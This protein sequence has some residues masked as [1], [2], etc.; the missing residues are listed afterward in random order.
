[1]PRAIDG[2]PRDFQPFRGFF[3]QA[4]RRLIYVYKVDCIAPRWRCT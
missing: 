1:L 2:K 3:S 4:P